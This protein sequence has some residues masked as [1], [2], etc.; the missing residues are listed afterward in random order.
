MPDKI[1]DLIENNI[2]TLSNSMSSKGGI[3]NSEGA[4][5]LKNIFKDYWFTKKEMMMAEKDSSLRRKELS[6]EEQISNRNKFKIKK[7]G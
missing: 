5:D 2:R 4:M 7:D 3:H 6:S 1:Q